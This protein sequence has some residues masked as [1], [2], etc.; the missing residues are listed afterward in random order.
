ML[1]D[2]CK[3]ASSLPCYIDA[4]K[5]LN[6]IGQGVYNVYDPKLVENG[7][8]TEKELV[9]NSASIKDYIKQGLSLNNELKLKCPSSKQREKTRNMLGDINHS[10]Y[11]LM[12]WPYFAD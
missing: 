6:Y 1:F 7:L 11:Y 4:D 5:F 12:K 2:Y 3:P 10:I 9:N 8:F